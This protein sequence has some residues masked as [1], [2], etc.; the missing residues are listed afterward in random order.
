MK[1][2]RQGSGRPARIL[3]IKGHSAGIGDILRSSAAWRALKNKFPDSQLFLLM[4]TKEPGYVSESLISR[5]H[6]LNGFFVVDKRTR[7][8]RGWTSF[9]A[10]IARVVTSAAPDLMIDF[11]PHGLRT[12]LLSLLMRSRFGIRTIG[13][14]E[15]PGRGIFYSACSPSTEKFARERGLAYPLEYTDK[16]FVVLSS[17]GIERNGTPIELEETPEGTQF[18]REFRK[19]F[20]IPEGAVLA[21]VNI[22]CGTDDARVKR[23]DL[24]VI[25]RLVRHLEERYG[26]TIVLTGAGFEREINRDFVNLHTRRSPVP[27]YDL[28][29]E[30]SLLQL[31]GLLRECRLFLSSD[32]GPYH[33]AAAL[34][35][36]TLAVFNYNNRVHFHSHPWVKCVIVKNEIDAAGLE[37]EADDLIRATEDQASLSHHRKEEDHW[38]FS[39]DKSRS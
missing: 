28:G 33:M 14:N 20:G 3:M 26:Y 22:G 17:L 34:R 4:L 15:V 24:A 32:S 23:P 38:D 5:H 1:T 29:G 36:P 9:L 8:I 31:T 37:R 35:V 2:R 25:S 13:I 27:L 39:T 16:D 10:E 19:R 30:T 11:E 12:S 7:G 6:L 18:R 21:G